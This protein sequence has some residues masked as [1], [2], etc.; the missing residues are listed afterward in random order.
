MKVWMEGTWL[1]LQ[2]SDDV[3]RQVCEPD[4]PIQLESELLHLAFKNFE[5]KTKGLRSES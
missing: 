4:F 5:Y 2:G 3:K 1:W